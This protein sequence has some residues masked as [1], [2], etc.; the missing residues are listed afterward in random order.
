MYL[1]YNFNIDYIIIFYGFIIV[2]ILFTCIRVNLFINVVYSG[3]TKSGPL[4]VNTMSGR[5]ADVIPGEPYRQFWITM[6][7]EMKIGLVISIR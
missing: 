1:L 3:K 5:Y 7:A 6:A 4:L 2:Y